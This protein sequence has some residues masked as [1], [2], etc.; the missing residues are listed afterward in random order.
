[1]YE[2]TFNAESLVKGDIVQ[3]IEILGAINIA[4][5]S[6]NMPIQS[7]DAQ[8][9]TVNKPPTVGPA[10]VLSHSCEVALENSVKVT[11]I[12]LA[13]I[14]N[15]SS[16]TRPEKINELIASNLIDIDKPAASFLKYFYL[17]PDKRL[18]F[19]DGGVVDFS[20]CFSLRKQ[21][22]N[23][24]L[25]RKIL[26]LCEPTQASMSLKLALYFHR[27]PINRVFGARLSD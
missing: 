14:R 4:S 1:M 8:S 10:M 16:A 27:D 9:W 3:D 23:Y 6:H 11:S 15:I 25:E 2:T 21:S 24:V 17:E 13:P 20:K 7:G 12:V 22:Y 18:P 26:Q 5:I 19:P